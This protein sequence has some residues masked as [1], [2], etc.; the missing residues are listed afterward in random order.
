MTDNITWF[1]YG[2]P[3]SGCPCTAF[4]I[5]SYQSSPLTFCP[6]GNMKRMLS[7]SAP[8]SSPQPF[9]NAN[10][11][12][13]LIEA[14]RL[15][16]VRRVEIRTSSYNTQLATHV[17]YGYHI[18]LLLI[19]TN[20]WRLPWRAV[21]LPYMFHVHVSLGC[22]EWNWL[23]WGGLSVSRLHGQLSQGKGDQRLS[24]PQQ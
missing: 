23:H 14:A 15:K 11:V 5:A 8:T 17:G 9:F 7:M 10:S 16:F 22:S 2:D 6:V 21:W 1:S 12:R 24:G 3:L 20:K 4:S 18:P 13:T 19:H